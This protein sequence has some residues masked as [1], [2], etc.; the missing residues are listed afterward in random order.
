M[1]DTPIDQL[2]AL[3]AGDLDEARASALRARLS[4][5]EDGRAALDEFERIAAFLRE[6][7]GAEPTASIVSRAKRELRRSRP[8]ISE[9]LADGV[10]SFLAALD[11]DSRLS[12][13]VAGFRGVAEVAQVAFSAEPC[14]LDL[15]IQP[16]EDG[17]VSVRGQ[18]A[19]DESNGWTLRFFSSAGDESAQITAAPDGAFRVELEPGLYTMSL[20]RE[21]VRVEA[22]PLPLP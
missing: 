9:R 5:T 22:G 13:A 8:G 19:A 16:G 18:V 1:T 2:A 21:N 10:L 17:R 6:E 4:G 3:I 12:P 11:F 20:E 15:E 14:E 7:H